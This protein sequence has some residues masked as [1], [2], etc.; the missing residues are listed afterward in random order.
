MFITCDLNVINNDKNMGLLLDV[1]K[2]VFFVSSWYNAS[3]C[4]CLDSE[5]MSSV[6]FVGRCD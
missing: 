2:I 3:A 5:V 1:N 6:L 4:D